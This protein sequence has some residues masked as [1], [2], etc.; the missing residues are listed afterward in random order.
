MDERLIARMDLEYGD[1][2]IGSLEDEEDATRSHRAWDTGDVR[3]QKV[4]GAYERNHQNGRSVV[5]LS[6][7]EFVLLCYRRTTK[8]CSSRTKLSGVLGIFV[9]NLQY[10]RYSILRAL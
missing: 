5:R 1:D 6:P 9:G 8:Y 4:L 10:F 7:V 3:L 2:D